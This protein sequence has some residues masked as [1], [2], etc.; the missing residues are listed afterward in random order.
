MRSFDHSA[1]SLPPPSDERGLEALFRAHRH[2]VARWA[3][4]LASDPSIDPDDIVQEVFLIVQRRLA[5]FEWDRDGQITTW[6]F[7]ITERVV[8]KRRARERWRRR[9]FGSAEPDVAAESPRP[10]PLQSLETRR[11][12]AT[13]DAIVDKLDHKYRNVLILFELEGLSGEEIAALMGVKPATVRVRLM[14]ARELFN[15]HLERFLAR[16]RDQ[17]EGP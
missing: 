3:V 14:R 12:A 7:R 5:E 15:K 17:E 11:L 1:A 9:L 8:W 16:S 13:F 4:R 6:L 2:T 10:S